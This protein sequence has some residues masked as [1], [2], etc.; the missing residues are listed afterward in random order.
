MQTK[1]VGERKEA[2]SRFGWTSLSAGTRTDK[3]KYVTF[4]DI[5][6]EK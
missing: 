2:F 4:N 1:T 6:L 3:V 5:K